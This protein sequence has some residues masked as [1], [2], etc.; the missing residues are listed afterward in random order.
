MHCQAF[1]RVKSQSYNAWLLEN[2]AYLLSQSDTMMHG[3]EH[4]LYLAKT[5]FKASDEQT[6]VCQACDFNLE[7][8]VQVI[9][10][11]KVTL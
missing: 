8:H 7:R 5:W 11:L 3:T 4:N 1:I 2:F 6:V 9:Y 10:L